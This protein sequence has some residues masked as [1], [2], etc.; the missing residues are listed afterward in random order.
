MKVG[1]SMVG[2]VV[3]PR[4]QNPAVL[5]A[6]YR[7]QIFFLM[8]SRRRSGSKKPET[9]SALHLKGFADRL[10]ASAESELQG[11]DV[12][13]L[14]LQGTTLA[15]ALKNARPELN[16]TFFTPEHFFFNTL[17]EYHT[18]CQSIS[19]P[20]FERTDSSSAPNLTAG[21]RFVRTGSD[22]DSGRKIRLVCSA[23]PP[24]ELFDSVALPTSATGNAEQTQ[25][26]IQTAHERLK[27]GGR[28]IVST[29]N[30][31]DHWLHEQLKNHFG[32]TTVKPQREGVVYIAHKSEPLKKL[33]E[34]RANSAFRFQ[35]DLL[36]VETMPG[37]FS[38]RRV[39]GGARALIRSLELL[40]PEY[41][42]PDEKVFEPK[43]IVDLGCGS[44]A[45]GLAAAVQY[46]NARV[47][48]VDSHAR[49]TLCAARS[50]AK[51]GIDRISTLLTSDAA[52]PNQNTWDLILTNPPYY[53]D[54]RI[55]ELFLTSS[56]R[57]LRPG[58]RIHLV[59]KLTDWH[60]E[61]ME[62]LFRDI[63]T[64]TIGE[65]DVITAKK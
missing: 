17:Q 31:K 63:E 19:E 39:D 33:K 13:V 23:D 5:I 4:G 6:L 58:G 61:R 43:S 57:A 46:P 8:K 52:I 62:Q 34:F 14:L 29:N 45:V 54:F 37:V 50:A 64:V 65:Y 28:L 55:S 44:G 18:E 30:A 32:R 16:F 24:E 2:S 22:L 10:V 60:E 49:A 15:T 47:L 20:S 42:L 40:R 59:T 38:H 27:I 11:P 25:E 1:L 9:T 7:R 35:G 26:L 48:A 51:N 41:A 53:S 21:D 36:H 3:S 12:L 56:H